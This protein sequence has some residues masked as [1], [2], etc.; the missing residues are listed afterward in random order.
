M[1]FE[2]LPD[3]GKIVPLSRNEVLTFLNYFVA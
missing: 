1:R 2:I 3:E